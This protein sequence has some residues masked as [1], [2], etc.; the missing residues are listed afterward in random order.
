MLTSIVTTTLL[1][2]AVPSAAPGDD[3]F[4]WL[5]SSLKWALE[6]FQNKNYMPAIGM[7]VMVMVWVFKKYFEDKVTPAHLP[8]VSAAMGVVVAC[9]MNLMALAAGSKPHDWLTAI[10]MGLTMGAAASG[11]WSLM[12]KW[13]EAKLLNKPSA[14]PPAPPAPPTTPAP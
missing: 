12:G 11:F 8:Y 14:P 3:V 6:Q 5:M 10:G 13:L 2:Q 9:A 4:G 1:A 7:L